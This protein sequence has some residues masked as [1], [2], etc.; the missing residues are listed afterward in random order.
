MQAEVLELQARDREFQEQGRILRSK[1]EELH[2]ALASFD[3]QEGQQM[4]KLELKS[5]DAARAWAWV[6]ANRGKFKE[7][8]Y[9]PPL[10]TCSLKDSRYANAIEALLNKNDFLAFTTQNLDDY[11][12]LS[13]ELN[14]TL[15]LTDITIRSTDG[16]APRRSPLSPQ[17]MENFA[18]DAWAIDLVDGPE[19]V[20]SMLCS[21]GLD[22][23]AVS[24]RELSQEHY[25]QIRDEGKLNHWATNSNVYAIN[26]RKEYGPGAVSS[27]SKQVNAAQN[28]T[29]QPID[30]SAK[31]EIQQKINDGDRE[32]EELKRMI[33]P[34]RAQT[35]QLN[36]HKV[37]LLRKEIVSQKGI[38]GTCFATLT[39]FSTG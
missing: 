4:N 13:D 3:T 28:W 36:K 30:T 10:V 11:K 7:E 27:T 6:Q 26:R 25:D 39:E 8:V 23:S 14:G 38:L 29:D 24:L 32:F 31:Q 12:K 18:L 15:G 5:P 21:R 33:A 19:P 1:G 16:P 2:R 9:G 34:I 22:T 20:L 37:P 17:E 35:V